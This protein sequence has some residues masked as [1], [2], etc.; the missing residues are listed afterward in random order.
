MMMFKKL[1]YASLA[2]S[3]ACLPGLSAQDDA[4]AE[5]AAGA[6]AAVDETE[7][8]EMLGYITVSQSGMKELGF[9]AD[10]ADAIARGL[11]RGLSDDA[12]DPALQTKMP[13][14]QAFIQERAEAAQAKM[15]TE[16]ASAAEVNIAAGLDFFKTLADEEGIETTESGLYYKVVEPGS[17]S[18]PDMDD[19][20]LVHYE[21]TRIDGTKF[22]SSYDRGEPAEFPLRGVVAGFGEGITKIGEGGEVMLY[23]PSELGYGNNPRP[24]GVIQP[25]DTLIFKVELLDIVSDDDD[26]GGE[27]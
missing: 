14:F 4:A 8:L 22:D 17:E 7:M 23:I 10:E 21:G 12:P 16:Q 9:G 15:E 5:A 27:D 25:G 26:E 18:K 24:G 13:A 20:V 1:A 19:T 2:F 3:T 11:K 6:P